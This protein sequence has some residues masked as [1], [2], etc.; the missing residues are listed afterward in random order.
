MDRKEGGWGGVDG[1]GEVETGRGNLEGGNEEEEMGRGA[2]GM[3]R[4][5]QWGAGQCEEEM[6]RR[7]MGKMGRGQQGRPVARGG[8]GGSSDPP[9]ND[10]I[11]RDRKIIH[12]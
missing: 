9:Q 1:N 8:S 3:G 12:P 2:I 4:G 5:W 10:Q 7:A 6:E 11:Q